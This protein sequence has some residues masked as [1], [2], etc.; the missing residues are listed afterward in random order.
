MFILTLSYNSISQARVSFK[1]HQRLALIINV[2][3]TRTALTSTR[4]LTLMTLQVNSCFVSWIWWIPPPCNWFRKTTRKRTSDYVSRRQFN[5]GTG[6]RL[7]SV[8]VRGVW[9]TLGVTV[10]WIHWVWVSRWVSEWVSECVFLFNEGQCVFKLNWLLIKPVENCCWKETHER[11]TN[12]EV[13]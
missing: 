2:Q 8:Q 10:A 5:R 7:N 11:W 13:L 6:L 12:K 3:P 9:V 4:R 1:L